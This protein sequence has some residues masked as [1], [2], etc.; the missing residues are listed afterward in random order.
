LVNFGAISD[1]MERELHEYQQQAEEEMENTEQIPT[2]VKKPK[3]ETM[4]KLYY[5]KY[6]KSVAQPGENVGTIAG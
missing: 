4:K 2:L 3:A 1:K 5:L 6:M